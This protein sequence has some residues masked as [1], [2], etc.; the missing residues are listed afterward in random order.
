MW[1]KRL[2]VQNIVIG[3]AA[4]AFP[5]MI[6]WSAVT[7][8]LDLASLTLFLVIFVWTPPHF[9]AL[10]LYRTGDY[11][12]AGVPMLPVVAGTEETRRQILIYS[13]VMVPVSVLPAL[14]GVAG[15]LYAGS[16]L[17]LSAA[18]LGL[19][20]AVRRDHEGQNANRAAKRLFTYSLFYLFALFL[21]LLIERGLGIA[22]F[23]PL[24]DLPT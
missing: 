15:W 12:R 24:A 14:A 4:G 5:P 21:V 8:S 7:G 2:T 18:F 11:A 1:L 20:Y 22:P 10:A 3:G 16:A 19:A 17:I 13:V 23:G 9:W 6:G